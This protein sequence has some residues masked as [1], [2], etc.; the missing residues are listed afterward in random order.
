MRRLG[1]KGSVCHENYQQG[2]AQENTCGKEQACLSLCRD[3]DRY[4]QETCKVYKLNSFYR[5]TLTLSDSLK[6]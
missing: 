3:W 5:I 2:E 1:L 6:S 4:P